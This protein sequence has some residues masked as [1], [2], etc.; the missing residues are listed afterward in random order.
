M[1]NKVI[2]SKLKIS[3]MTITNLSNLSKA[4]INGGAK[5]KCPRTFEKSCIPD[6]SQLGC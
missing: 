1:K 6:T 5:E 2:L 4:N 3:K